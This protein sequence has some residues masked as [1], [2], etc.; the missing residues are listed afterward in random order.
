MIEIRPEPWTEAHAEEV[1][2]AVAARPDIDTGGGLADPAETMR[3]GVFCR[4]LSDGV[5][6]LFY[7]LM[8]NQYARGAEAEIAFAHGRAGFDLVAEVLPL[9]EHQCREFDAITIETRRKGLIKKL[10]AAGYEVAAVKL[11]KRKK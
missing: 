1:R 6:V 4:V 8:P 7:V 9:I 3:G 2:R 11:R 5:P 10:T